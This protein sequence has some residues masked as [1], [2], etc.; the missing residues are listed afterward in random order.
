MQSKQKLKCNRSNIV[1]EPNEQLVMG[2]SCADMATLASHYLASQ[3][4]SALSGKIEGTQETLT[5]PH[6]A[7]VTGSATCE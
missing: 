4:F 6:R 5:Q 1:G 3:S 7:L 2:A